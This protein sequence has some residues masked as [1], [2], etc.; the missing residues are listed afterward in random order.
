MKEVITFIALFIIAGLLI[1]TYCP[2]Y[3]VGEPSPT[4]DCDDAT[5]DMYYQAIAEGKETKIMLGNLDLTGEAYN[6]C[7]HVWIIV[8]GKAYDWGRYY[9]D[10]QHYEGYIITYDQLVEFAEIDRGKE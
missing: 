2:A 3:H 8:D 4:Y 9:P 6:E 10:P 7:N 5:L 1:W